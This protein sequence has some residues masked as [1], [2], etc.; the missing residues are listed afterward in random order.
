MDKDMS[1]LK[2]RIAEWIRNNVNEAGARGA[3]V[4]LSGGV[5]SSTVAALAKLALGDKVLGIIM[6]CHSEAD[7]TNHARVFAAK[8]GVK[9]E[10][11]DLG[12]VFDRLKQGLPRGSGLADANIK[13]RLRMTTLYYFANLHNYVVL[14]TDNKAELMLGY[15]TKY[16]DGGVDLLPIAA[17]CKRD[18]RELAKELGV[19]LEIIRKSPSAGLWP[20]QTDEEEMGVSYDDVDTIL[21]AIEKGDTRGVEPAKLEKIKSMM[22]STEHKR[23]LP[24]IFEP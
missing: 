12:P 17:L 6:P 11:V 22:K 2:V 16:G 19:P 24:E 8:F 13:P 18:V 14:G 5:D 20:G 21:E 7:D 23:R 1:A 9:T 10:H 3:V 4:G 15:F